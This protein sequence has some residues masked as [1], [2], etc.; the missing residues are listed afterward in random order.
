MA[1]AVALVTFSWNS[2]IF[3]QVYIFIMIRQN[4]IFKYY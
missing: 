3:V 2:D 1:E 4:E